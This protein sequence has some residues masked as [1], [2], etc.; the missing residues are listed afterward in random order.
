MP[1]PFFIKRFSRGTLDE[2]HTLE[3]A[4]NLQTASAQAMNSP[5]KRNESSPPT[6]LNVANAQSGTDHSLS[7]R[8]V[9]GCPY[10]ELP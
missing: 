8:S 9:I 6:Q 3:F 2:F 1:R 10:L 5:E 7:K 4:G